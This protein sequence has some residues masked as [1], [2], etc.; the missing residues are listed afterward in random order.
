[1]P[2]PVSVPVGLA[3]YPLS[4]GHYSG[5]PSGKL[6]VAVASPDRVQLKQSQLVSAF[7][8]TD[9]AEMSQRQPVFEAVKSPVVEHR[10]LVTWS[11]KGLFYCP[12]KWETLMPCSL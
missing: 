5:G 1:M 10:D 12:L 7:R 4:V 11:M 2:F 3:V 6:S 9:L 8:T